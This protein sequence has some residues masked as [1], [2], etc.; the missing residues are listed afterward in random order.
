MHPRARGGAGRGRAGRGRSFAK[1]Q[2]LNL[3]D[4]WYVEALQGV[5]AVAAGM[6]AGVVWAACAALLTFVPIGISLLLCY[7]WSTCRLC[8]A[9]SPDRRKLLAISKDERLEFA[10]PSWTSVEPQ[11]AAAIQEVQLADV[12]APESMRNRSEV[13]GT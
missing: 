10:H 7:R 2:G 6:A 4:A 12:D 1:N 13:W 11:S 3:D 5:I 8:R 9:C